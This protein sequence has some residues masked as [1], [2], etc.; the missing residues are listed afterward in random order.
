MNS[1]LK[2]FTAAVAALALAA[3]GTAGKRT[4]I[5]AGAGTA[6]GAGLGALVGG[7]KGALI[8]A[9][10]GAVAGGSVGLYLDKQKKE[11]EQVAETR[12]TENGLLVEMKG[13]ILFDSNSAALKTDAVDRLS[14]VGDILAKYSDNRVRVEGHTDSQGSV[15][16]N[17][18][19]SLRRAD[20]VKRVL[21]GR[22]VQEKQIM[23]LGLGKSRPIADNTSAA[24]RAQ[25]RRVEL[26]IDVPNPT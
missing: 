23:V 12:R 15:A 24:G 25:N 13:D 16:L 2:I 9:G 17:E 3:C 6:A 8:G 1:S 5:G 21:V 14:Q 20:A 11:L 26:H 18:E 19:L 4:A 22:G 10:V 7:K